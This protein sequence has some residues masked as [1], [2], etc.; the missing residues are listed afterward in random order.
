LRA[1]REELEALC[2]QLAVNEIEQSGF[3]HGEYLMCC[4]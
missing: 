3:E 2:A 4:G 1:G